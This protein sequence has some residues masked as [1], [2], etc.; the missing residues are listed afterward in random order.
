[1]WLDLPVWALGWIHSLG[2]PAAHLG[3]AWGVTKMPDRWFVPGRG[4]FRSFPGESVRFYDRVFQVRRWKSWLPDG[5]TWFGGFAKAHLKGRDR[6]YLERFRRETCRGEVAHHAQVVVISM[7]FF[8]N[9]WPWGCLLPLYALVTN[10][11]CIVLQR[12]NRLRFDRVLERER[13]GWR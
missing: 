10:L 12:Q 4:V 13:S 3:V 2:V 8:L 5:A 7:F 9:P 6:Q 1:M 11:P